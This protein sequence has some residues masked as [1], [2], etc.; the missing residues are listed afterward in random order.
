MRTYV[1][2]FVSVFVAELGDK[3]QLATMLFATEPAASRLG[4]F[5]AAGAALLT[6]T[7][8]AVI[9][10]AWLGAAI[11]ARLVKL[12]AGCGFIAVGAWVLIAELR[13]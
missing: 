3:T 10:G 6:S 4:I 2:V 9:A 8:L 11:P 5:A 7:L 13:T 12:A 1:L